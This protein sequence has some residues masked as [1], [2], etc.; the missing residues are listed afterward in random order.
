MEVLGCSYA[1][2]GPCEACLTGLF[3]NPCVMEAL[4]LQEN[5]FSLLLV[6]RFCR[7]NQLMSNE[8]MSRLKKLHQND[9]KWI[10]P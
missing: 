9:T 2:R 3:R 1:E 5:D 7:R 8:L 10:D 6:R 4:L